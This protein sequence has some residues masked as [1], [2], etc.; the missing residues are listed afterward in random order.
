MPKQATLFDL[1][2]SQAPTKRARLH[3]FMRQ[4]D[5]R[6]D[7]CRV[8]ER[9]DHPWMVLIPF[10]DDANKSVGQI[11]SESA[12]LYE[13][14]GSVATGEGELSAVRT[15]CQQVGIACDL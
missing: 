13:A 4:H 3:A 10:H 7:Y 9:A 11:M 6:S 8:I 12:G 5:I 15:L 14:N 1:G 2:P